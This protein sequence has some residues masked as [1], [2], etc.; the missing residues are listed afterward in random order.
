MA[1]DTNVGAG[2]A[3]ASGGTGVLAV[4]NL[5]PEGSMW[6]VLLT[7][8]SP[9]LAVFISAMWVLVKAWID[10]WVSERYIESELRKAEFELAK[11]EACVASSETIKQEAREKVDALRLIKLNLHSNRVL[12]V[13]DS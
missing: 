7:F 9:T 2:V 8:A 4:V 3:G 11:I 10:R 13:V 1:K 6:R 5:L 12:A